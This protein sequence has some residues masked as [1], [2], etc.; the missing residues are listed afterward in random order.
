MKRGYT[1]IVILVLI[2]IIVFLGII[3]L[4]VVKAYA[5][6]EKE[7]CYAACA[8]GFEGCK[9][10]CPM[11]PLGPIGPTYVS[12]VK[13][14]KD[15]ADECR[16]KCDMP[17]L[18]IKDWWVVPDAMPENLTN[19]VESGQSYKVCF[20]VANI[21]MASSG[22]FTVSGGGLGISYNPT[23]SHASLAPGQTREGC[24]EY[25]TTPPPGTYKLGIKADASNMVAESNEKNNERI[26][27][28]I[29]LHPKKLEKEAE[30]VAQ[31]VGQ[32]DLVITN[33]YCSQKNLAFV[34]KNQGSGY[35]T[36]SV[37][38]KYRTNVKVWISPPGNENI[39]DLDSLKEVHKTEG[40]VTHPG[41]S[42]SFVTPIEIGT[43]S[44]VEIT[45]DPDN[46]I[47][48]SNE[49]NNVYGRRIGP[50]KIRE[51]PETKAIPKE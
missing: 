15:K 14:C 48:E 29:I 13:K 10:S 6:S 28:I 16:K 19:E 12:C 35:F 1:S 40:G 2:G 33:I 45:I 41:G 50:C 26:E 17:D 4:L 25:P 39:I 8:T 24:L 18:T 9:A 34:V 20:I 27:D 21:G 30:H 38:G 43:E 31:P 49:N 36:K 5:I 42:S 23:Q 44:F 32:P 3:N 51:H 22:S 46:R 47:R 11:D 37:I 7:K